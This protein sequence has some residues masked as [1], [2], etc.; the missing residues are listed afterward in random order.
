M[1]A[2]RPRPSARRWSRLA[3]FTL[4]TAALPLLASAAY[5]PFDPPSPAPTFHSS[6]ILAPEHFAHTSP[7]PGSSSDLYT[8]IG[9][10]GPSAVERGNLGPYILDERGEV[11]WSGGRKSVL[12]FGRHEYRGEAV[13]AFY[14]GTEV[15]PGWGHGQWQ[16]YNSSYDL[17]ATVE[18]KNT[19]ANSTDPHDFSV[20]SSDTAIIEDWRPRQSDLR[21]LGGPEDGW[22][23]DCVIQ[24]VDIETGDLLFEWH[25]LEHIPVQ[26]TFYELRPGAGREEQ[27]FDAHHLNSVQ[28]DDAGNFLIS[29][30]GSSTVY[31]ID[32]STGNILWRVG[33]W[34]S[35]FPLTDKTLFH[36]QHHARL[37]G[38]G[39]SSPVRLS[40]FSNGANQYVATA[41]ESR[42]MILSLDLEKRE[43]A[44]EAEFLPSFH[45]PSSSEG[46]VQVLESGNVVVGWGAT[47][48]YSE[49]SSNGT[50]LHD[51]QFGGF[52]TR[53]RSDHSYRVFKSSW[54][55]R[56]RTL[57]S[58]ALDNSTYP[59][60][61]STAFISWNG[62]TEVASY[63]LLVGDSPDMLHG[64]TERADRTGFETALK[65][66]WAAND[67]GEEEEA[68]TAPVSSFL[69]VVPYDA[70]GLPLGASEVLDVWSGAGMGVYPDL[71]ALWWQ[72]WRG[73]MQFA[74]GA[75]VVV[76]GL[77]TFLYRRR[78]RRDERELGYA[79]LPGASPRVHD[80]WHL[81]TTREEKQA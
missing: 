55:G 59:A 58:L 35:D 26:E 51:V 3:A 33:R 68:P 24:E 48:F 19:E 75:A 54:V 12:N 72:D 28:R 7:Q 36:F 34:N 56:P 57:P 69:T 52:A 37:H 40:L 8:F 45:W 43:A 15:Y 50:V 11:V 61:P 20:T 44:L 39:L 9:V 47:P 2:R 31:Y 70:A 78:I 77:A 74:A 10:R 41:P 38:S 46:S 13:L 49:Y 80:D 14:T 64:L 29:L 42:G 17:V 81:P 73:K 16:L 21:S 27:P 53:A 25:A 23:F 6:L 66:P 30:R 63:R 4:L 76:V 1:A 79:P 22:A 32:R 65:L 18:S 67:D 60:P 71:D 62:A 5:E